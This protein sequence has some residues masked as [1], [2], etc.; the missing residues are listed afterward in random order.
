LE[1][2]I[3]SGINVRNLPDY[4]IK[5]TRGVSSN[6]RIRTRKPPKLLDEISDSDDEFIKKKK[7]KIDFYIDREIDGYSQITQARLQIRK[8]AKD[9]IEWSG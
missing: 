9:M 5:D 6:F 2:R 4:I 1:S 8:R 7:K 3:F